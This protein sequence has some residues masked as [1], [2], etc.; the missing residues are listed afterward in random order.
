MKRKMLSKEALAAIAQ[1]NGLELNADSGDNLGETHENATPAEDAA[2]S[3]EA[4]SAE[5]EAAA[6]GSEETVYSAEEIAAFQ[7]RVEALELE[8][9]GLTAQVTDLTAKLGEAEAELI[10]ADAK[11]KAAAEESA[12]YRGIVE[13]QIDVMRTALGLAAVDMTNWTNEAVLREYN[14]VADS[15]E[16][17]LPEGSQVPESKGTDQQVTTPIT[18]LDKSKFNQLGF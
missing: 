15:F 5:G 10:S 18:S 2:A 12:D 1:K 14:S 9:T 17:A 11:V 6:E 16:K 7:G 8:V 3:A 4:P 13:S